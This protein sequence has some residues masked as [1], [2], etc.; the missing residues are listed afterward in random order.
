MDIKKPQ[1]FDQQRNCQSENGKKPA[2]SLRAKSLRAKSLHAKSL[3]PKSLRAKSLAP[4]PVRGLCN[5]SGGES[6]I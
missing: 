5:E 2:K 4:K 6:D 1:K 3:R